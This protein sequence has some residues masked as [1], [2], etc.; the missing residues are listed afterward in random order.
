MKKRTLPQLEEDMKYYELLVDRVSKQ[1]KIENH[2]MAFFSREDK[3][4]LHYDDLVT[5]DIGK[6]FDLIKNS[7]YLKGLD[8]KDKDV[9]KAM[10]VLYMMGFKEL[11]L[12]IRKMAVNYHISNE[13]GEKI[14]ELKQQIKQRKINSKGG[15]G[16]TSCHK[17]T[18]LKIAGD[19]WG[20][21]PNASMESLSVKIHEYLSKKYRGV[22]QPGTIKSWL[23]L[24][25][26]NP[27][28]SP[29]IR[30]YELV[31]K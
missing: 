5:M 18:A 9:Y 15:H 14:A 8:G 13:Y 22:P 27:D 25:K 23:K 10:I 29:K 17:E 1:F 31:I 28:C 20:S 4:M 3:K 24:S 16:R 30:D 2:D 11:S 21:F 12:A 26:L 7:K 19:T 6:R